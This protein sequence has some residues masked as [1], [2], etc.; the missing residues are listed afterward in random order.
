V[1]E[2]FRRYSWDVYHFLG[3]PKTSSNADVKRRLQAAIRLFHADRLS[4]HF[5]SNWG[6]HTKTVSVAVSHLFASF[7]S[8]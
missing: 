4:R 5:K 1:Y 7:I 3:I 6:T 8:N 2:G